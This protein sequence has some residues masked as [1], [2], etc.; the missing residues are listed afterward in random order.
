[1]DVFQAINELGKVGSDK[2][3]VIGFTDLGK[4]LLE[5]TIRS[6][7]HDGKGSFSLLVIFLDNF[8]SSGAKDSDDVGMSDAKEE[9]LIEEVSGNIALNKGEKLESTF[10]T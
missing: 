1:M 5:I 10:S 7:L 3:F 6:I 2:L 8:L 9:R 4:K